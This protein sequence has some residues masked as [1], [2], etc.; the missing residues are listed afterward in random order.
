MWFPPYEQ[1][2]GPPGAYPDTGATSTSYC[3]LATDLGTAGAVAVDPQGRIYV[4]QS[5]GLK[6][7]RF[8]P[9]FPTGP[10]AAGGCGRTDATGAPVA[11]SVQREVFA[12]ASQGMLSFS[13]LAL[14][15][16]GNL[17]AASV[18]TGRI[19][20][21][22]L[23]GDLVRF[24][25]EPPELF[26]PIPTGNPQGI[27]VGADG[28]VYY[29]DLDLVGTLPDVGPGPNGSVRRIT[30]DA[31]ATR[32]RQTSSGRGW[33]SPTAWRVSPATSRHRIPSRSS[34]RR[35]PVGRAPV[36]QPDGAPPHTPKTAPQARRAL[37]L[38]DR[39]DRDRVADD[40]DGRP[41]RPRTDA[42]GV[43][44]LVGRPR[45]RH[46]LGRPARRSGA[47]PS[48]TSRA[49]RTPVQAR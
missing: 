1:F 29:A 7:E 23:E 3:K 33:P 48:R 22:D 41:A 44:Q 11:D 21:Y 30:F 20:E 28:S 26:P 9:P 8:S 14:A 13:G 4:A 39:R 25:L 2:P 17:Y 19:A 16:N 49:R 38:P 10:D 42:C 34:G 5:S 31:E 40:R 15:P 6:I 37:A 24:I 18:F 43:R 47:S 46:R 35:S 36:L 45:L 27:A 12:T 32:G